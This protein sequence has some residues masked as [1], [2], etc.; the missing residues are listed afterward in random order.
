MEL[1]PYIELIYK[2]VMQ[3]L[4]IVT[5]IFAFLY[6]FSVFRR[7]A[8]TGKVVVLLSLLLWLFPTLLSYKNP[9]EV[10][11]FSIN[12]FIQVIIQIII[13]FIGGTIL[14]VLIEIFSA[15]G[16]IISTQIGFAA[17][18]LF[19]P[20]FGMITSLTHFYVLLSV[21]FFFLLN[22][23][24]IVISLIIKSFEYI[25]TN[26]VNLK[27]NFYDV[28]NFF[29]VIF[30]GSIAIAIVFIIIIMA[31]NISL[32]VMSKFAPQF[33]V[34]SVGFNITLI[35]GSIL[36]YLTFNGLDSVAEVYINES[37]NQLEKYLRFMAR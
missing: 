1:L 24:L 11:L 6:I 36:I 16:Q 18:S 35:M 2:N 26:I 30:T 33:N 5:R 32:A 12:F 23:H 10:D 4:L 21:L 14:N 3:Y 19:D 15:F 28:L 17:A 20:R 9:S 7:E 34:F 22:G 25:P 29:R 27:V 8:A 31:T 13:G 37:I